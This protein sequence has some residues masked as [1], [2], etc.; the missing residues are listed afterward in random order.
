[1]EAIRLGYV[2]SWNFTSGPRWEPCSS[3]ISPPLLLHPSIRRLKAAS[4]EAEA[5]RRGQTAWERQVGEL[6]GRC[7]SLEEE[8]FEAL[9]KVRESVQLAEEARLEKDQVRATA[10]SP[11]LLRKLF[12]TDQVF[13]SFCP[14]GAFSF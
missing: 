3:P 11:F 4:Q 14:A 2:K 1:M 12:I 10:L 8:R 5:V 13:L 7:V 6:Q 9:S